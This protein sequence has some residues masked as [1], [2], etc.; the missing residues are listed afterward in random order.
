MVALRRLRIPTIEVDVVAH[1]S[2]AVAGTDITVSFTT[3][4]YVSRST[5]AAVFLAESQRS[6][7]PRRVE[8]TP[9]MVKLHERTIEIGVPK[10][11]RGLYI[12]ETVTIESIDPL[13][14]SRVRYVGSSS[15]EM[16]RIVPATIVSETLPRTVG[17]TLL[18]R[19]NEVAVHRSDELIEARS[20]H[21]GDDPHRIH[22]G[23][24]AHTNELFIRIGDELPPPSEEMAVALDLT[25]AVSM[26][27]VDR[28]TGFVLG[29]CEYAKGYKSV[30]I[31]LFEPE[32]CWYRSI[33]SARLDWARLEPSCSGDSINLP[34]RESGTRIA[35]LV[36]GGASS[37]A[38]ATWGDETVGIV[39]IR[40]DGR[41]D[42]I[43][44]VG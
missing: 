38:P 27:Q 31:A 25:G 36:T 7:H 37:I 22:W 41:H 33:E 34:T 29:V 39:R 16:V 9:E 18:D 30:R 2:E 4:R 24:L 32:I 19:S 11:P 20:Y 17:T 43:A 44:T 15:E 40:E 35:V 21:P 42:A 5:I 6:P 3:T 28:M 23:M 8:I 26:E 13:G 12:A 10:I 1:P 14:L